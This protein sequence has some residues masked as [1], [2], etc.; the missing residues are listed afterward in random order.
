[1]TESYDMPRGRMGS[2]KPKEKISISIDAEL[3]D[4][5]AKRTGPGKEFSSISHAMERGIASLQGSERSRG[6][7]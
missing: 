4:W 7:R 3:Y 5:V 6:R 2:E 1:M